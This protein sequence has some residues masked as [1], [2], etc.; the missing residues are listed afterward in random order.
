M[1]TEAVSRLTKD[2]REA[3]RTLE[4]D[5]LRFL[6]DHYYILQDYRKASQN[7]VR[8]LSESAEPHTILT[9]LGDN[10][11][12]LE[13]QI[14]RALDVYTDTQIVGRW[15]KSITGIGPVIAAGLLAHIDITKAPTVGH[16][17]RFAGLDPTV[18]WEPK[19]RR[20]WNAALKRLCWIIGES[21]VKVSGQASD[22]Y[23]KI[24]AQRKELEQARN[25]NGDFAEQAAL[26][27][28]TKRWREDTQA[29][30]H[31]KAGHLPPARIHLRAERYATKLF[32]A[33]W[34]HVAFESHFGEAPPKPYIIEHGGHTD[35][36]APPNWPM[37]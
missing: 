22:I 35:Y 6:V 11:E 34:H 14:R 5:E 7:Q 4:P 18:K 13:S 29:F 15:S 28:K 19:T 37:E 26:S 23:G 17:W 30:G 20:P 25:A 3:A 36:I 12:I 33:H 31:Y 27:L 32:L 1:E 24:Y 8:A 9:W 2:L 21:F 10:M 16:I